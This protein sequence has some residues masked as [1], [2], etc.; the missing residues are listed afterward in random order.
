MNR[1]ILPDKKQDQRGGILILT[2]ILM[3]LLMVFGISLVSILSGEYRLASSVEGSMK[4]FYLAQS[5]IDRAIVNYLA[6]DENGAWTD[7]QNQELIVNEEFG[8]GRYSVVS[9][10]GLENVII[11]K[12]VGRFRAVEKTVEVLVH[13]DRT[14]QPAA[15]SILKWRE[16]K[17]DSL[18]IVP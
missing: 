15:I 14:K 17:T 5:G 11:L 1:R 12:A 10:Q 9:K 7:D 2:L 18:T 8:D 16:Q 6:L 4:A 13:I 3:S